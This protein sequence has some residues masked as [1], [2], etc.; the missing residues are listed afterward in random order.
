MHGKNVKKRKN[1]TCYLIDIAVS[2]NEYVIK[3]EADKSLKEIHLTMEIQRVWNVITYVM[4]VITEA[5][6]TISKS[7]RKYQNNLFG[8][9]NIQK[10]Q[11]TVILV[12]AHMLLK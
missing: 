4:S 10:I 2:G 8:K 6:G 11:K 9:R 7:F 12:A 5:T 1:G 3:K